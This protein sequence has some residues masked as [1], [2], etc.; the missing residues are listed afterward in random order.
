MLIL[1]EHDSSVEIE[2]AGLSP[3]AKALHLGDE[4]SVE[5]LVAYLVHHFC[6]KVEMVS[7]HVNTIFKYWR[8]TFKIDMCN[9]GSDMYVKH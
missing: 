4:D 7:I 2:E 1:Q 5:K 3:V 9:H 6:R 8:L